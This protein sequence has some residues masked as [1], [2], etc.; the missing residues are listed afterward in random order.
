MNQNNHKICQEVYA[1]DEKKE[2][3]IDLMIRDQCE[4]QPNLTLH[5]H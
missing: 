3:V 2:A 1:N 5:L 4:P